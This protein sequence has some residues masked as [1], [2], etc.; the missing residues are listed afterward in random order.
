[1]RT[2]RSM[3]ADH[4]PREP[5]AGSPEPDDSP[6]LSR[7]SL[8]A[9]AAALPGATCPQQQGEDLFLPGTLL[10]GSPVQVTQIMLRP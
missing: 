10:P 5:R 3:S 2:E 4:D 8:L 7:R 9:G 6:T 1:M